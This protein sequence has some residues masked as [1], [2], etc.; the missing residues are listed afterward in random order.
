MV[1]VTKQASAIKQKEIENTVDIRKKKKAK[2]RSQA[3][4]S[5]LC[6]GEPNLIGI[7]P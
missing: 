1:E 5:P 3:K 7:L 4:I 6:T 2:R